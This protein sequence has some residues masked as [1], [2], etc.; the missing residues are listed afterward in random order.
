MTWYHR[1]VKRFGGSVRRALI[2]SLKL[3]PTPEWEEAMDVR[4]VVGGK[5]R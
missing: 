1:V 4:A 5:Y 2:M 3:H